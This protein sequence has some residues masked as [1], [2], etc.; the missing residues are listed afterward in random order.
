MTQFS[1]DELS[2]GFIQGRSLMWEI[3][4][5]FQMYI[6]P[7]IRV[8]IARHSSFVFLPFW[9]AHICEAAKIVYEA[10][11]MHKLWPGLH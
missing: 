2:C 1:F 9:Q 8:H 3:V 6:L 4:R 5:V 11:N 7:P 10:E